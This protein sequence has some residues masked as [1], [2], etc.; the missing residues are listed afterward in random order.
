MSYVQI[1]SKSKLISHLDFQISDFFNK[2]YHQNLKY[3][4]QSE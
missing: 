3:N 4:K 1:K 2:N